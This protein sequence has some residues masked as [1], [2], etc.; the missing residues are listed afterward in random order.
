MIKNPFFHHCHSAQ[1]DETG[2]AF[3]LSHQVK[4]C[5]RCGKEIPEDE[6]LCNECAGVKEVTIYDTISN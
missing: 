4:I 5:F 1:D 6:K 2:E 3:C